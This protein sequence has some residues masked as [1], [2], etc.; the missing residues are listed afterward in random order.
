MHAAIIGSKNGPET[1]LTLVNAQ[2]PRR[3]DGR[4]YAIFLLMAGSIFTWVFIS[5]GVRGGTKMF[6]CFVLLLD[7]VNGEC[8]SRT[9]NTTRKNTSE[10]MDGSVLVFRIISETLLLILHKPLLVSREKGIERTTIC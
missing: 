4:A 7:C 10:R 8:V 9:Q 5:S 3:K 2:R 6:V 1:S